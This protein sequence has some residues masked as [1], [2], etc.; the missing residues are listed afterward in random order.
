MNI[1]SSV[2]FCRLVRNCTTQAP[3]TLYS[4]KSKY[5]QLGF[6][7]SSTSRF[8]CLFQPFFSQSKWTFSILY[9]VYY[10]HHHERHHLPPV[11]Q[12]QRLKIGL[13]RQSEA[14]IEI[15]KILTTLL[16]HHR[17]F[18]IFFCFDFFVYFSFFDA[19]KQERK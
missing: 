13:V 2:S 1:S 8:L 3:S 5:S 9:F 16:H 17:R 7:T 14:A 6:Y 11:H 10:H 4:H 18:S 12:Y 19:P 15:F